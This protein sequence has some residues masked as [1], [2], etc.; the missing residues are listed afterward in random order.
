[1][2]RIRS[3]SK[4][5]LF[6]IELIIVIAIFSI[7]SAICIQVFARAHT[8]SQHSTDI[9]A[10]VQLAQNYAEQYK[11]MEPAEQQQHLSEPAPIQ[12][13]CAH[14][15]TTGDL[16]L[17]AT[18]AEAEYILQV[19]HDVSRP[20]AV[21]DVAVYHYKADFS[22]VQEEPLYHLRVSNYQPDAPRDGVKQ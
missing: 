2:K 14:D 5:G 4:S 9:G 6:L 21:T 15:A 13:L 7:A 8:A 16:F 10:A 18:D 22:A 3:S 11:A 20:L 1:M 19:A 12:Y 17:S